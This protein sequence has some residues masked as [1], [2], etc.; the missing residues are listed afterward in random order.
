[1]S[2][3]P[4]QIRYLWAIGY[5]KD[6]GKSSWVKP[7]VKMVPQFPKKK[8]A[9]VSPI[10][11]STAGEIESQM[12]LTPHPNINPAFQAGHG[13]HYGREM[14]DRAERSASARLFK[15]GELTSPYNTK[16]E[17]FKP[18]GKHE[19]FYN[20]EDAGSNYMTSSSSDFTSFHTKRN[21]KYFQ[22]HPEVLA[23]E[24]KRLTTEG[25][26]KAQAGFEAILK[27]A[28]PMT[29]T[30]ISGLSAILTSGRLKSQVEVGKSMAHKDAEMRKRVDENLF[31][32]SPTGANEQR[33]IYGYMGKRDGSSEDYTG[34]TSTL[35]QYGDVVVA[36]HPRVRDRTTIT[37]GDSM[38]GNV[39]GTQAINVPTPLSKP[40]VH[41]LG[42]GAVTLFDTGVHSG[43]ENYM[44]V[45]PGAIPTNIRELNQLS[46]IEAQIHGGVSV[47]DIAHVAFRSYHPVPPAMLK[48]LQKLGIPYT[49]GSG[50]DERDYYPKRKPK[51]KA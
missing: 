36:F 27:D 28:E 34:S 41:S 29:R 10:S 11:A 50:Q 31:G 33:P 39:A 20:P 15:S 4:G 22:D 6:K 21:D 1:M 18:G 44:G 38:D 14:V 32:F 8:A 37:N 24:I 26:P 13:K 43:F 16:S 47:A 48:K 19:K 9:G 35:V 17:D 2:L 45:K 25:L 23:A 7:G 46:Y 30:T 40:Q 12:K 5:F 51:V 3:S 49:V 42:A